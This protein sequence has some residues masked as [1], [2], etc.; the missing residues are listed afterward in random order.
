MIDPRRW[1]PR[2]GFI[3][4]LCALLLATVRSARSRAVAR[5]P[6]LEYKSDRAFY[7]LMVSFSRYPF[8][9]V[10]ETVPALPPARTVPP[11]CSKRPLLTKARKTHTQMSQRDW[12]HQKQI[13]RGPTKSICEGLRYMPHHHGS[14]GRRFMP[15]KLRKLLKYCGFI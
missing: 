7:P 6:A 5:W 14:S 8:H 12:R 1:V 13:V 15:L 11:S 10:Y 2:F 3:L 4:L 9:D